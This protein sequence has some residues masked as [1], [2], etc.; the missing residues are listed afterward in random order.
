MRT[1]KT[2]VILIS[3]KAGNGKSTISNLLRNKLQDIPG[4]TVFIYAFANPLKYIA[5][6]FIGW[7]NEKDEK[8]RR[9]LQNLGKVGR[10]YNENIWAKHM[11]VQMEKTAGM[12]PF[13]F[14][15]VD[16]WRFPNELTFLKSH[17]DL[18]IVTVRVHGRNVVM[19]GNTASDCSENSL[20]EGMSDLYDFYIS[21]SD[22]IDSLEKSIDDV[23]EKL[24]SKYII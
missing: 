8:G 21:N 24:S 9:L 20:P 17:Q 1:R 4:I 2:V 11:L 7:D 22:S 13:N 18:D 19:P 6:A 23:V 14:A 10:E 12:I 3:G 5:K 15:I 16:D